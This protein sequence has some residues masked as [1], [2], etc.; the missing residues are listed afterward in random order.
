MTSTTTNNERAWWRSFPR[1]WRDVLLAVVVL[2][3][4][5]ASFFAPAMKCSVSIGTEDE[6]TTIEAS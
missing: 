5:V 1:S 3:A 6:P 2:A 4:A